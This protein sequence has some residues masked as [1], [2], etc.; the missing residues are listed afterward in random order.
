[1]NKQ[2]TIPMVDYDDCRCDCIDRIAS[3]QEE[4]VKEYPNVVNGLFDKI[5][6]KKHVDFVNNELKGSCENISENIKAINKLYVSLD[7]PGSLPKKDLYFG[8]MILISDTL[9]N[10]PLTQCG[11]LKR[12]YL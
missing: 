12:S 10:D 11:K 1:M 3:L 9:H 6:F 7:N 4:L 8:L 5:D 2:N